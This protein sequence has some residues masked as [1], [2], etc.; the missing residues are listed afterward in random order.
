M[1]DPQYK[2]ATIK[3]ICKE[4]FSLAD[5][6]TMSSKRT[7]WSTWVDSSQPAGRTS[8]RGAKRFVIPFEG[9][10]TYGGMNGRDM[11]AL[12]VGLD[13]NTEFD[14]LQTRIKQG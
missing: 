11:A 3:E 6:M 12:S 7:V 14:M 5:I 1:R 9:F 2:D 10:L 8:T 4:M 13:E